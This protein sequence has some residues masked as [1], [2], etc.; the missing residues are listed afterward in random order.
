V[1]VRV[2]NHSGQTLH[3]GQEDWLNFSVQG[4][5]GFVVQKL[6]DPPTGHDFDVESGKV[7][8][9]RADLAPAF[10]ISKTGHYTV[11]AEVKLKDWSAQAASAP[12]GFDIIN[13][14]KFWE[15]NFGVPDPSGTNGGPP[16]VRKYVLQKATYLSHLRLYLRVTDDTGERTFKVLPIGT[17]VS[18]S[19]PLT[20]LDKDN[21]LHLL[22]VRGARTFSY[23]MTSPDGELLKRQTYDYTDSAPKLK[24]ETNGTVSVTGGRRH[25]SGDDLPSTKASTNPADQAPVVKN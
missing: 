8:T 18:F 9:Q 24:V 7:A 25:A 16:E 4:A 19:D 12:K 10:T 2:V 15:M 14:V 20:Q 22:Y 13:G 11:T 23:T 17:M 1:S 5:N 3:F 6:G 21:N